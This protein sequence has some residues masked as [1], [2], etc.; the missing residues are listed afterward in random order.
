MMDSDVA[1]HSRFA[2]SSSVRPVGS[3][4]PARAPSLTPNPHL[5][6]GPVTQ[7]DRF[8]L[9]PGVSRLAFAIGKQTSSSACGRGRDGFEAASTSAASVRARMQARRKR[10]QRPVCRSRKD[11]DPEGAMAARSAAGGR[12]T[13]EGPSLPRPQKPSG[14]S[15]ESRLYPQPIRDSPDLGI[16]PISP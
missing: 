13:A 9:Q 12:A 8:C 6:A 7:A 16:G 15:P 11:P 2:R 14:L 1:W 4:P 3:L 10:G 5:E